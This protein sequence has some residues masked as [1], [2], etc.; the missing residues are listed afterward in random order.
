LTKGFTTATSGTG[1]RVYEFKVRYRASRPL[2]G[3]LI[4]FEVSQADGSRLDE[5][6]IPLRLDRS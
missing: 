2:E 6:E 5:V 1:T 3:R 4:V